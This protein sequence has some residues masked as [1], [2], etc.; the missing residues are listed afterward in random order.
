MPETTPTNDIN[1]FQKEGSP[2][3]M[4]P[5]W[6]D[7]ESMMVAPPMMSALGPDRTEPS[8]WVF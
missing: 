4:V 2:I 1:S 8:H 7:R 6:L 3:K 5:A